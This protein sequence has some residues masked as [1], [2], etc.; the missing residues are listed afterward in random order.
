VSEVH[1]GTI[2]PQRRMHANGW[3]KKITKQYHGRFFK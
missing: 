2:I 1:A 3:L